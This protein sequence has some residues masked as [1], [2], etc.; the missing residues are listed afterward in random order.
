MDIV[1]ISEDSEQV[2]CFQ[3]GSYILL[4]SLSAPF[5]VFNSTQD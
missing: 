5:S 2:I 1:L 3:L 4:P